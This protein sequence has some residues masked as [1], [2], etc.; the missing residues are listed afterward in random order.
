MT[1]FELIR[2]NEIVIPLIQRDYAQGRESE[3]KK[4][5]AFLDAIVK[6]I[7]TE[8]HL[9]FIYGKVESD[10]HTFL[11]LDGQ[12][13][14]TTLLLIYWFVSLKKTHLLELEKFTYEVRLST[15]DFIKKL[16]QKENWEK[17]SQADIVASIENSSWFF[18]SWK[19][20][21]SVQALL[22]ML[23][24]IE[25]RFKEVEVNDLENIS[26]EFLNLDAFD[27]TDELYV[28]MNARGKPLSEFENFKAEF[29]K[30]LKNPLNRAKLDNE[31]L[32]IFWKIGKKEVGKKIENAPKLADIKYYNFFY[33]VTYNFYVE[34]FDF[35]K[36]ELTGK[37]LFSFYTEVYNTPSFLNNLLRILDALDTQEEIFISFINKIDIG[38]VER[39]KFYAL[40]LAYIN[41]LDKSKKEFN[42]WM[43]VTLNLINNQRIDEAKDFKRIIVSLNTLSK[44]IQDIYLNITKKPNNIL[45][46]N[47]FQKVEEALKSELILNDNSWEN[48]LIKAESHWYLNG[49]V[50]FLL[51]FSAND[52]SKFIEYRDKF[53]V[54]FDKIKIHDT[55]AYQTLI[56][57]ALLTFDDYLPDHSN[58]YTFCSYGTDL[59]EKG[60]NWR[61]VFNKKCF[62][63]LLD[64]T[65]IL[66]KIVNSFSFDCTDWRSYFINP[67]ETWE[68]I[69][70]ANHF[71]IEK[72]NSKIYLNKG[73]VG[74]TR[75]SWR[76]VGELY[77]YY[78]FKEYFEAK[79]FSLFSEVWYWRSSTPDEEEP[80]IVMRGLERYQINI[81]FKNNKFHIDFLDR[82][83]K[84]L[85]Q[86]IIDVL[87]ISSFKS[88]DKFC[89]KKKIYLC[90]RNDVF[91]IIERICLGLSNE[92][93]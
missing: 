82:D 29:S 65:R 9:D 64:D 44:S 51:K 70:Y 67:N 1:F 5:E 19:K 79:T 13:R 48:E 24:L 6:G 4:A 17:L 22:N 50:S 40:S 39:A 62:Q 47:Q 78:L 36:N 85:P 89:Y 18:L 87:E 12:Q 68:I 60:E 52:L 55:K 42:E 27:L 11:P 2:D 16:T 8:L 73:N 15:K 7:K 26:F 77:S 91:H 88:K 53:F 80:C 54:L 83:E 93:K 28:K 84:E 25:E 32:D 37:S 35:E 10:K 38:Y 31:W 45:S 71:Q 43:R 49:Q 57:R 58:K 74:V 92:K 56:H 75:W 21:P 46:F 69:S 61:Q 76:R 59:R 23:S 30:V 20:D 41:G 81:Y 90:N 3:Q 33:N 72:N 66:E 63:N 14:L 86:H 34:N